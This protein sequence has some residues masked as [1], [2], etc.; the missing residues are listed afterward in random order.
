MYDYQMFKT[1]LVKG[2]DKDEVIAYVQ[3]QEDEHA[4]QAADLEKETK[5]RDKMIAELK[6]RIIQKD[7]QRERLENEI[8]TRYKKYIDNYDK[9]GALVYDSQVKGD[10]IVSDARTE[11]A[12]ILYDAKTR[13]D[14]MLSDASSE[15]KNRVD[16]VQDEVD[17]KLADGKKKYLAVQDELNEVVELI[18]QVQR[19]FMQSYK[20]V[21]EI[22]QSMPASMRDIDVSEEDEENEDTAE[23]SDLDDF[24]EAGEGFETGE[25]H[26]TTADL[27]L[28]DEDDE[29][30]GGA[31]H[32]EGDGTVSEGLS[33]EK[34]PA[35]SSSGAESKAQA[36]C[37]QQ[38]DSKA[39]E[40]SADKDMAEG[41]V[42]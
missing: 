13:S 36:G 22:I 35:G 26:F 39:A 34:A 12:K 21:H 33:D 20:E 8:E 37:A 29:A 40:S 9:I 19:K 1:V 17:A 23:E 10:K 25:L 27:G 38:A 14:R 7:E 16:S 28:D 31:L 2:F 4:K 32:D 3:K 18:N 11:A 15:A 41:S 42:Q 6:S 5:N 24:D 30:A